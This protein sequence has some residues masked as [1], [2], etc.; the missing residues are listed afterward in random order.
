VA[1]GDLTT[2]ANVRTFLGIPSD[3]TEM[4]TLMAALIT[5][6]SAAIKRYTGR[7]FS[8]QTAAGTARKFRYFGGGY[9]PFAPYDADTVTAVS[10]DTDGDSPL[11]LTEDEDFY[12]LPRE[13]EF[14]VYTG[15]ELRGMNPASRTSGVQH[16]PWRQVTVTGTWGFASIPTEVATACEMLVAWWYRQQSS[17]PGNDL[18]GEGDRFGP[19]AWPTAVRQLLAPYRITSFGAGA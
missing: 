14:G 2:S 18:A 11:T 19:S 4:N 7:E 9:M 3:Q 5:G 8:P 1:S 13:S 6:A 12:L 16:R 17:I 15:M 10:I